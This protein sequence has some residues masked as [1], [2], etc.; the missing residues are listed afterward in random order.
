VTDPDVK[1][2][3]SNGNGAVQDDPPEPAAAADAPEPATPPSDP[4]A[5][6]KAEVAKIR[7]QLLRTAA[8]FDNFRKRARK[9][10]IEAEQR[11]RDELLRDLL[12]VF[13]NLERAVQHAENATQV[14]A[15]VEGIRMVLRQFTD[16]L[17]KMSIQRVATIG[18]PFDPSVHEAIQHL[19]SSEPPGTVIAEVQA[20]YKSGERLVRPALVVVAKAAAKPTEP[21]ASESGDDDRPSGES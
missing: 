2:P 5:E 19:E 4:V 15:V 13:D 8:D 21:Q 18:A 10:L 11:G 14:A 16:T 6:A 20:G 7:D 9:E 1:Q 3:D 17:G 12:P